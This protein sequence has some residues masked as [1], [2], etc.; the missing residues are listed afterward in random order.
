MDDSVIYLPSYMQDIVLPCIPISNN[1]SP[2]SFVMLLN[3][4]GIVYHHLIW[5]QDFSFI[6]FSTL[7]NLLFYNPVNLV[8]SSS[9]SNYVQSP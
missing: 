4:L 7:L 9:H 2:L 1:T 5:L 8:Q 3:L 6:T